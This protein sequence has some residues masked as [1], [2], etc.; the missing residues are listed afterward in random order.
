MLQLDEDTLTIEGI[1]P[2]CEHPRHTISQVHTDGDEHYIR[3]N[4]ACGHDGGTIRVVCLEWL[5]FIFG[6]GETICAQCGERYPSGEAIE[7][8]GPVAAYH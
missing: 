2:G 5:L 8:L 1:A 4:L 6:D 3:L 7:D